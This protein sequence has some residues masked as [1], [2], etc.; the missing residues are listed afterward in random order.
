MATPL[1]DSINAL[2]AYANEVTGVSDTTLSDAVHTLASG[3]GG[4]TWTQKQIVVE[5]AISLGGGFGDLISN[6]LPSGIT[7][8]IIVKDN[9]SSTSY[10]SNQLIVGI[11]DTVNSSINGFAR[12]KNNDY[13]FVAGAGY[14]AWSNTYAL[15]ASVG[16]TY[17]LLY[18]E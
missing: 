6:N 16:D 7:F 1:T 4:G 17:T 8:C 15:T 18:Q 5:N 14:N 12:Y 11:Y 3:Y 2:T 10:I 9:R 13:T